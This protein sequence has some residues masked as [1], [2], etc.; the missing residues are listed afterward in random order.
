MFILPSI[1]NA[2]D[3]GGIRLPDGRTV[4]KGLLLRGGALSSASEDDLETLE[5]DYH[6][7]KIFDFRMSVEVKHSPDKEVRG[8]KY[9][10][11]PAFDEDSQTFRNDN[12]PHDAYRDLGNWLIA[13][14]SDP[15]VRKFAS[16][17]YTAPMSNDFTRIQY[18]GFLQ[19]IV[20]TPEGA[21]YWHCSQGKD[22]TGLGAAFVLAAL[23][24]DRRTIMQD[25]NVSALYYENELS[26]FI[27]KV[28][29]PASKEVLR[30][31]IS[32]NPRYFE[33]ALDALEAECGSMHNFLTDVLLLS[34]EDMQTLQER[35]L[36]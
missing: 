34:E 10:W 29:D 3:L 35:Y 22:R 24:A 36:Y 7:A 2:R 14:A 5:R 15:R 25:Y 1:A 26:Q 6:L 31:F 9:I 30:T 4:R 28:P 18:A 17:L 12:L 16:C 11:M 27:D 23:G 32:V 13:N 20:N 19:N 33:A 8:A 21:V